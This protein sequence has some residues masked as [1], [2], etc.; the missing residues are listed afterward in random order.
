MLN[1]LL[2]FS[3]WQRIFGYCQMSKGV[4]CNWQEFLTKCVRQKYFCSLRL[5]SLDNT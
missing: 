1:T 5:L 3:K 2:Q 4:K